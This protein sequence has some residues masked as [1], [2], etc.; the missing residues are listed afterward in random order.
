[1]G[2]E[3]V[4]RVPLSCLRPTSLLAY[5]K[6]NQCQVGTFLWGVSVMTPSQRPERLLLKTCLRPA[7]DSL[8]LRTRHCAAA[9]TGQL[10]LT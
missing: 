3:W 5:W 2:L 6:E 8:S 4:A 1:M 7:E 10:L 9:S